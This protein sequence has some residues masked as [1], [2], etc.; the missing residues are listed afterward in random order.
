MTGGDVAGSA[1]AIWA[2]V[3]VGAL[4]SKITVKAATV[5]ANGNSHFRLKS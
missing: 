3:Q 1:V 2:T 4:G 5:A